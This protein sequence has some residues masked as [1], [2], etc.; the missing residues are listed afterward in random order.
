MKNVLTDLKYKSSINITA[1]RVS[2]N[3]SIGESINNIS[4]LIKWTTFTVR[5]KKII[6]NTL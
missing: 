6:D 2:Y 4:D 5:R 1:Y 3:L